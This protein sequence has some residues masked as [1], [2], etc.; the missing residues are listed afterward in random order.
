[1]KLHIK[2]S[3]LLFFT[4][5]AASIAYIYHQRQNEVATALENI[6]DINPLF[7][8]AAITLRIPF[9]YLLALQLHLLLNKNHNTPF[10]HILNVFLITNLLNYTPFKGA[11]TATRLH[12][13]SKLGYY[14][15]TTLSTT[16]A[17]WTNILLVN[18]TITIIGALT[19]L[20]DLKN[21]TALL[22]LLITTLTLLH[23]L[24][25]IPLH[26]PIQTIL[27]HLKIEQQWN[28][29]IQKFT[30]STTQQLKQSITS[31]TYPQI[32]TITL[33]L[34]LTG[35]IYL[36]YLLQELGYHTP[37]TY[38]IFT[39]ATTVALTILTHIPG[40][41]GI[42]QLSGGYLLEKAGIPFETGFSILL[43]FGWLIPL[44]TDTTITLTNTLY[45][46]IK[47]KTDTLLS[48]R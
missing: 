4:I 26:K 46:K 15:S 16:F 33:L 29:R 45:E 48:Q 7:F 35:D 21:T 47:N 9:L 37:L 25:K 6:S 39:T 30:N 24:E 13:L 40:G 14:Y 23:H 18:L 32:L 43:I 8:I 41:L 2:A 34:K 36:K 1:M 17:L 3:N 10:K 20:T 19:Y 12:K 28:Q 38:I 5:G 31:K 11:A 44:T 27:N 22:L 42:T